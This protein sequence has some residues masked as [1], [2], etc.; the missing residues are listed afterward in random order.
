MASAVA[1]ES[2]ELLTHV[3]HD[4]LLEFGLIPEFVG[5]LPMVVGLTSLDE[6]ALVKILTE[7]KNALIKQYQRYFGMDGVESSFTDDALKAIA[8]TA[9]KHKTGARGLRTVL[10]ETLMEV[11]YDIPGRNDI[12]K[13]VVNAEAVT[14]KTRPLLLTRGGQ[15]VD[16]TVIPSATELRGESA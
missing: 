5:R 6:S 11:M 10:E 9:I 7:P 2:D 8:Q 12:R 15:T 1:K 14:N 4:D 3:T 16:V 13:C